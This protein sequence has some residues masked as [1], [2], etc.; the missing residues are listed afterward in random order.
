ME[1]RVFCPAQQDALLGEIAQ[2]CDQISALAFH[3]SDAHGDADLV[4]ALASAVSLMSA[5]AG[6]CSEIART[7]AA[8]PLHGNQD[9]ALQSAVYWM[10]PERCRPAQAD[11]Q[12]EG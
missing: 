10:L 1:K 6:W 11:V 4:D 5:R 12:M 8:G 3:I 7:F 9:A 2:A